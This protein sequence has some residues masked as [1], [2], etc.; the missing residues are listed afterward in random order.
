MV[1]LHLE[2]DRK[3]RLEAL[4]AASDYPNA[5][6]KSKVL[7]D[8]IDEAA[9]EHPDIDYDDPNPRNV[10]DDEDEYDPFEEGREALRSEEVREIVAREPAPAI[11]PRHVAGVSKP[12]DRR[13]KIDLLVAVHR[14]QMFDDDVDTSEGDIKTTVMTVMGPLADDGLMNTYVKQTQKIVRAD[15]EPSNVGALDNLSYTSV[16]GEEFELDP[17]EW[18]DGLENVLTDDDYHATAVETYIE[19]GE[20]IEDAA[21]DDGD[22]EML[23]RVRVALDDLRDRLDEM[24]ADG[25]SMESGGE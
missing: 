3:A 21:E 1:T 12:R 10:S 17:D 16:E 9:A 23:S 25:E 13:D 24:R 5:A 2:D 18:F 8:L 20:M 22:E 4:V 14:F 19:R 11:N 7:R 6:G 15:P